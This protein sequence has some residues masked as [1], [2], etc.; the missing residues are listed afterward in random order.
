MHTFAAI[1]TIGGALRRKVWIDQIRFKWYASFYT[2]FVADPG[3]VSKSTTADLAMDLLKQ[4]PGIKFGPDNVTWQSLVTAFAGSCEQFEYDGVYHPMSPITLLASEFGNMMNLADQDMVNLF[5]TLWDGRPSYEK[6]TKMSG[7]DIVEAPWINM[8]AC[9]TPSWITTN[10]S[11][12]A[13]AGG[14]TS[15]TIYVFAEHKENLVVRPKNAVPK[16]IAKLREDLIHDLEHISMNLVGEFSFTKAAEDWEEKWYEELWVHQYKHE[17]PDWHKGYLARKQAHLNKIA[18]ILSISEG[19][20]LC[21][22]DEHYGVANNLLLSLES[23]MARVFAN[24]GRS[25]AA[26]EANRLIE[27]VHRNKSISMQAAYK[28]LQM[29]FPDA[30]DF[31]GILQGTIQAGFIRLESTPEGMVLKWIGE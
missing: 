2:V 7:N 1:T 10:M 16:N 19:D 3:I 14:L 9:T 26:I 5:I 17:L 23:D 22:T 21:I 12:L 30:R 31:T 27:I 24:V 25:E 20:S 29:A 15:R 13:T 11:S 4:V 18:M 28:Q 8:L 6:Q